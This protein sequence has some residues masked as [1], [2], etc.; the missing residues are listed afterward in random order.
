VLYLGVR[1]SPILGWV[2]DVYEST[3]PWG[4]P[5]IARFDQLARPTPRDKR[6]ILLVVEA[7]QRRP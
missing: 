4:S 5:P 6:Q 2:I 1:S 3:D 7:R